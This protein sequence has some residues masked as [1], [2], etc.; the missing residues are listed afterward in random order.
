MGICVQEGPG[1][2]Y[3][4]QKKKKVGGGAR[5]EKVWDFSF[6]KG[7]EGRPVPRHGPRSTLMS[8]RPENEELCQSKSRPLLACAVASGGHLGMTKNAEKGKQE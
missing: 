2:G 7:Y 3:L 8:G 1:G 6:M 4:S 5:T